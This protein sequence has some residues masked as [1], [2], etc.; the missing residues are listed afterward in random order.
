MGQSPSKVD[1]CL[2]CVGRKDGQVTVRGYRVETAEIE[3][4]LLALWST[5]L[6][7]TELGRTELG[8]TTRFSI[9]VVIRSWLCTSLPACRA[10]GMS[11][12]PCGRGSM[13]PRWQ[14]WRWWVPHE[15]IE[16]QRHLLPGEGYG[17]SRHHQA[18]GKDIRHA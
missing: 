15:S 14:I 6:G 5:V 7:R 13:L 18:V 16:R 17:I 3:M 11:I 9:W 12:S 8:C 10:P 4:A 2:E 1:G